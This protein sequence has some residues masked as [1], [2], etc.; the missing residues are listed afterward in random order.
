MISAKDLLQNLVQIPSVN[1]LF[2]P[3]D[4][5]AGGE[6]KLTD[7]LEG[8]LEARR[9]PW[10]R[11]AVHPGRDN[12]VAVC[13]LSR[14]VP[15]QRPV[16]WEVHQDTVG[17]AG[18]TIDPFAARESQ[19]RIWGRGACDIKGG[20]AA[21]LSALDK[22]SQQPLKRPILLA[23]TIN[24]ESGFSGV[25]ALC[26]LWGPE[27]EAEDV[28]G[29][30]GLEE[31]RRLRPERAIVAE[32]TS[33]DVVVAHKGG[34]RWQCHTRGKAAHTSRPERGRNAISTMVR[35]VQA[36]EQ[37]QVEVLDQRPAHPLCGRPTVCVSTIQGGS[38]GNTVPDHAVI[39][40]D[41]R[42]LPGEDPEAAYQALVD[43]VA[44]RC[45]DS[46]S[47]IDH[48]RPMTQS[49]GLRDEHNRAWAQEIAESASALGRRSQLVGVPYGT[50]A[51]ALAEAGLETVVFGPG[52][53]DQAHTEDEWIDIDQLEQA[54][55]IFYRLAC[56]EESA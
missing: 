51:W 39:D 24:E 32:P 5:L 13:G 45:Q 4:E 55:E 53:I 36:I 42:L 38:G 17:V 2:F 14:E 49:R 18:M 46:E 41:R 52:S 25:Q 37:Y 43:Y 40:I 6:A 23:L 28:R 20:M 47:P 7:F 8:F 50:D 30:L 27:A 3:G 21:M 16:L 48:D 56:H 31:F 12:L 44:V 34:V 1:P 22:I 26:R 33:L 35:V 29:P 10:F 11:Q 9:F 15:Q 19:G 54:A